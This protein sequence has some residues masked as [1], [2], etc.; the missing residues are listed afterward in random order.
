MGLL[1][2]DASRPGNTLLAVWWV[3]LYVATGLLEEGACHSVEPFAPLAKGADPF[4]DTH[5]RPVVRRALQLQPGGRLHIAPQ[6]SAEAVRLLLMAPV[7]ALRWALFAGILL[8]FVIWRAVLQARVPR[9]CSCSN[10]RS[11]FATLRRFYR[12]RALRRWWR[13]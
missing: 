5:T 11:H 8:K 13:R 2:H 7:V 3:A 4:T 9:S 1:L 12:L 10:V 6:V